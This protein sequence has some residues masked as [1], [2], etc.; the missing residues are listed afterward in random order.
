MSNRL[1]DMLIGFIIFVLCFSSFSFFVD[2]ILIDG[3]NVDVGFL[4]SVLGAIIGALVL[5]GTTYLIIE[6]QRKENQ[7]QIDTQNEINT[8]QIEF[9]K[10]ITL[11][12]VRL[13][14]ENA[15]LLLIMQL[16]IN[17]LNIILDLLNKLELSRRVFTNSAKQL[18]VLKQTFLVQKQGLN[19]EQAEWI[20]T[21][22]EGTNDNYST[23]NNQLHLLISK[24]SV[25]E[26]G[27]EFLLIQQ[28]ILKASEK[29]EELKTIADKSGST[30]QEVDA[31]I[32]EL[33][34]SFTD[35]HST[36]FPKTTSLIDELES[37]L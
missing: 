16:K 13:A 2:V 18:I 20:K 17:K 9:Q 34:E 23:F 27:L 6:S 30:T 25:N 24:L 29:A 31:K 5:G 32:V 36:L 26:Y 28:Y 22:L 14:N 8:K 10:E 11:E 7:K 12:Q 1:K 35:L 37:K 3:L 15:K 33:H 19:P 4:G 21:A